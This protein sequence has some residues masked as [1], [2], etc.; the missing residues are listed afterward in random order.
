MRGDK[1]SFDFAAELAEAILDGAPP[2]LRAPA[3]PRAALWI[4][5]DGISRR[6]VGSTSHRLRT[7]NLEA[8]DS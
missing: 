2:L 4:H 1:A 6:A 5:V 8:I 7:N 3:L